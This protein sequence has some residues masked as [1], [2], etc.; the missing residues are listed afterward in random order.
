MLLGGR[1]AEKLVFGHLSTG[2]ADDL[3][4]AT[5]IARS[6][7]ARYGMDEALGS[8][9]YDPERSRFLGQPEGQAWAEP[10]RYSEATAREIDEAVRRIVAA[11]F[12][13]AGAILVENR[14]ILERC[15]ERLLR[16]ETLDESQIAELTADLKP[17]EGPAPEGPDAAGSGGR[18]AE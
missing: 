2:A 16:E 8:V 15:A 5:E 9:T 13:R 6:M 18:A 3:G 10:R 14:E 12:E 7:V 4:K 1:A 11:D 17:A